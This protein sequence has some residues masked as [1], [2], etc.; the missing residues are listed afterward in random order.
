M[1]VYIAVCAKLLQPVET[2]KVFGV[3]SDGICTDY[4]PLPPEF[5]I[6]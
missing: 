2:A 1:I 3:E 4:F 6:L 5:I